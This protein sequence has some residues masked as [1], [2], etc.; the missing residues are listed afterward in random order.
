MIL[1]NQFGIEVHYTT[2]PS[3]LAGFG[4]MGRGFNLAG[5]PGDYVFGQNGIDDI[6]S[7]MMEL[8]K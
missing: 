2:D 4:G 5:N 3:A 8:Q 1:L 7:Q 6:I